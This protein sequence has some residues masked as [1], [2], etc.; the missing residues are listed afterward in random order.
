M[1]NDTTDEHGVAS[2]SSSGR[3]VIGAAVV[4]SAVE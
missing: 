4:A 3:I 1:A 2:V